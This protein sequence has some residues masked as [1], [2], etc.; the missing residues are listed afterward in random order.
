GGA[1][2]RYP[3]E[4]QIGNRT[5]RP[6]HSGKPDRDAQNR[7][8]RRFHFRSAR[9]LNVKL[10][11]GF[12]RNGGVAIASPS[13]ESRLSHKSRKLSAMPSSPTCSSFRVLVPPPRPVWSPCVSSTRSPTLNTFCENS[14]C[15]AARATCA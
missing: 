8:N 2:R 13:P 1:K 11:S 3:R 15:T 4:R 6:K 5:D 12:R 7:I 14:S 10:D 9:Q